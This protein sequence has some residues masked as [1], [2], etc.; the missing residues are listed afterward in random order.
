MYV[1][2]TIL[3]ICYYIS[4]IYPVHI[5]NGIIGDCF[6]LSNQYLLGYILVT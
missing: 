6:L 1:C 3:F 5:C 2:I 4:Y